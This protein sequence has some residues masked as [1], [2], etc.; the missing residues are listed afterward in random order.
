M[1]ITTIDD[2]LSKIDNNSTN[3]ILKKGIKDNENINRSVLKSIGIEHN[4]CNELLTKLHGYKLINTIDELN[5]G[6]FARVVKLNNIEALSDITVKNIGIVVNCYDVYSS[7][8]KR[9]R[10]MIKC[11][12]GGLFNNVVFEECFLFQKMKPD[13]LLVMTLVDYLRET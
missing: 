4:K 8:H 10:V 13:D 2:I 11:K 1:D 3:D 9:T 5:Y 12:L 7:K 6:V